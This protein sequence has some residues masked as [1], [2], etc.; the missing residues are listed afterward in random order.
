M[1]LIERNVPREGAIVDIGCGYGFFANLMACRSEQRD[2]LGIDM[3]DEK[4]NH[5]LDSIGTRKNIDFQKANAF[6]FEFPP[7]DAITILDITYLLDRDRQSRL[8]KVCRRS[9]KAGGKFIWKTQETRP[10]WKYTFMYAQEMAG[11][12]VGMTA[13]GQKSFHFLSREEA[14]AMME[15][16]GFEV[17]VV[18]MPTRLPYTDVL[19]LGS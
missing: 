5:A 12:L 6:K 3:E 1:D 10:R 18:E 16:A 13:S 4:I 17:A 14:C 15:E 19:Y 8:L 11:S 7:C 2:V 9:L